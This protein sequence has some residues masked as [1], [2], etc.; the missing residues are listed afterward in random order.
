MNTQQSG[1]APSIMDS[2][3]AYSVVQNR[4]HAPVFFT[5]L[6]RDYGIAPATPD[7]AATMLE[8][9]AQIRAASD[10][11]E[12]QAAANQQSPLA[13]AQAHLNSQL[14]RMGMTHIANPGM[15]NQV[16]QAAVQA[17][18][19]PEIAHAILSLQTAATMAAS[20]S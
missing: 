7:E 10:A 19:D 2:D 20:Q 16:K 17:A 9:A 18:F 14:Q 8:M 13:G 5:K 6:A 12:K 3:T 4:I 11:T 1:N 15:Q